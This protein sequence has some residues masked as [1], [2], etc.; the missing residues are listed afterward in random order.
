MREKINLELKNGLLSKDI[1]AVRT[2]RLIIAAIKDRDIVERSSGNT[3]GIDEKE[4]LLLLKK[5]I[6]QREESVILYQK[7]KRLD[8]E[9]IEKEE[10]EIISRFLPVQL[11]EEEIKNIVKRTI[12]EVEAKSIKDMGKV[13][14]V[15]KD[16]YSSNIDFG[17][18]S[19]IIKEI[20]LN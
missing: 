14:N 11:S 18:A 20:L 15:L 12:D 9:K 16:K 6:K 1:V 4:I 10:I 5:M 13:M 7:G 3:S 2:L 19:K 8:L 17:Y